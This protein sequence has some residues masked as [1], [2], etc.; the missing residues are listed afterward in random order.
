MQALWGPSRSHTETHSEAGCVVV[1]ALANEGLRRG[2]V[3]LLRMEF[4]EVKKRGLPVHAWL[5]HYTTNQHCSVTAY[6]MRQLSA[7]LNDTIQ[8][9]E[10]VEHHSFKCLRGKVRRKATDSPTTT[11]APASRRRFTDVRSG[12]L[13]L[14][15]S[16]TSAFELMRQG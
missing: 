15:L 10:Y 6:C 2:S 12:H 13:S 8:N 1:G 16:S 3:A 14:L 11:L 5:L 7:W 4:E 9:M